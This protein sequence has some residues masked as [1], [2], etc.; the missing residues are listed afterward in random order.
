MRKWLIVAIVIVV[1]TLAFGSIAVA[2]TCPPAFDPFAVGD[3][4]PECAAAD[5]NSNGFICQLR[6]HADVCIDDVLP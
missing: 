5:R 6:L 1:L 4:S 3:V 2:G